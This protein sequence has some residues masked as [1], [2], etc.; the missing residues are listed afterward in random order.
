[1]EHVGAPKR[2][3]ALREYFDETGEIEKGREQEQVWTAVIQVL[4]EFVEMIGQEKMKLDLF[5][6][7]LQ[8]GLDTLE[9]AH[10]PPS[11]DHVIVGTIDRSRISNVAAAFLLGV[12][13][14]IWPMKPPADS[15]INERERELLEANGVRLAESSTRQLLD[16]NFICILHLRLLRI[17]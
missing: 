4:D 13:D 9:F 14:G 17:A 6:A 1:F 15:I 11:M 8:A 16:D 12:N 7:S 3:E 2:L 5:Q 10:V